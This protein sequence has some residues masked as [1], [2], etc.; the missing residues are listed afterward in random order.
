MKVKVFRV[1]VVTIMLC[2]VLFTGCA[3]PADSTAEPEQSAQADPIPAVEPSP[4]PTEEVAK[5][6][7][8]VFYLIGDGLGASQRQIAEYY[9][10]HQIG[11]NNAKLLMNQMPVAGINTTYS[12]DTLVTDSAAAGTALAC[13]IK[14]NNKVIA[15]TA[16]G[17][18]TK[19]LIEAVQ[20]LGYAT[21]I[22]TST[23]LTH[24]TPAA[25]ASHNASRS[26]ENEIAADFLES[27]VDFFAGG[28]LRHFLPSTYDAAD[29]D[30]MGSTIKSKRED[31]TDLVKN[32]ADKGYN[33]FVGAQG[34]TDFASYEP[35]AG[36]KV[37][38]ALTYSHMPY[39]V[40][41]ANAA[42][43]LLSLSE[44]ADVAVNTLSLDE[45]GF[46]LMVEA[47]RI[48]HA[49]HP[50]DVVAAVKDTIEFDEV[51]QVALDFYNQHPEETL[52]IVVGDHETGG[53]GLGFATDYFLNIN[54]IDGITKSFEDG[55]A[56]S[57]EPNGDRAAYFEMLKSI[58][59]EDLTEAEIAKIE[60]G[61]DMVDQGIISEGN[62]Y[63]YN[64]AGLAVNDV[65]SERVGIQWTTFAH[66]GTQIPFGVIG[67]SQESFG[68]F[69]DNTEIANT[70]AEILS[71]SIG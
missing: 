26:N 5:A 56:Y 27:N 23:R 19:T 25:F 20:E 32:F 34:T 54:Q 18:D 45:D 22:V 10:Q 58:G 65:V 39:E 51:I 62:A 6:P 70:L 42:T 48:D 69:M 36:D 52:I 64:E 14:T 59:I 7:K 8:Y 1:M 13:G 2:V 12:L 68:G 53:M 47:G 28:G 21:G 29:E 71:V 11:D 43:N 55:Y 60:A 66:T 9:M 46:F 38:A 24:A 30:P 61:M 17:K 67:N 40:D 37:F 4:E 41:R 35:K 44:I 33:V 50:N 49:C 63:Q 15:Q 16:D 31:E 3:Q 57:Y